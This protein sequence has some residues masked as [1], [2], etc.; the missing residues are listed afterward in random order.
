MAFLL[1]F[2]KEEYNSIITDKKDRLVLV[3]SQYCIDTIID[4]ER[5]TADKQKLINRYKVFLYERNSYLKYFP[6][7]YV[8][9]IAEQELKKYFENLKTKRDYFLM[10]DLQERLLP[11]N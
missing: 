6:D 5:E 3:T 8:E 7:E 2:L 11:N 1:S 10:T 9:K 4:I